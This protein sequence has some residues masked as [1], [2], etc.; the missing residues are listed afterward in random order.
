M[1]AAPKIAP[2]G[3]WSSPITAEQIASGSIGL[4]Q[5]ALDARDIYW[6]EMRPAES[7]RYVIVRLRDG[8]TTDVL[9]APFSARTR[10][11]EYGGGAFTV[12]DG[13]IYFSNDGDQCLYRL[14]PEGTPQ[15][16]TPQDNR[17]YADAAIDSRRQ[18]IVCVCEDHRAGGEPVNTI[19]AVNLD[20]H[21]E[22][23]SLVSGHD[24]YASPRLSPDGAQL[25]WLTWN[26]PDM[27]WDGT[28]L[29]LADI[30][31]NGSLG[32]QRRVAGSRNESVFQPA[33]APDGTLYF[34][35]DRS[36]WWN[37]YRFRSGQIEALAPTEAEFGLP[38]W[39][40]GMSTYAFASERRI[41]CAFNRE[42]T[43]RLALLD[44]ETRRMDFIE[45][46][47]TDIG[48]VVAGHGMA[49]FVAASP[50]MLS[51]V[52]CLDLNTRR[53][54]IL[55]SSS[56]VAPDASYLAAP[57]TLTYPVSG[58][59]AAHAF[60]YPPT[61]RD[62][63]APA[64]AKPPLLVLSHGGPT[65]AT[66]SALNLK[67]QYW[68][69]RGF[70]VLD[71]NYRGS[72]GYGRDYRMKLEGQW[73]VADVEDCLAGARYLV[74]RGL[75]D[76]ARLAIRGGSAGGYTTLCALTFHDLFRAGASYY[77]VS[78]LESLDRD[79]H[80][81]EARYLDRL[82]GPYPRR[83]DLYRNRSPI[84]H[85]DRLSCPV[86]FFQGLDDKVVPPDQTETMVNALRTKD[87]PVA[88]VPLAGESHGFRRA[89]NIRRALEAELYFYSRIFGFTPAD[90]IAPVTIEN[91]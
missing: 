19:V 84:H 54:E 36:H 9:P 75:A 57:Q 5:I 81:F 74:E 32:N 43:W 17:R 42:A 46:P 80:K 26:H 52:V 62:F 77:G 39:V 70:A 65:S 16:I 56:T 90:A 21:G 72:T 78:D 22:P 49:V 86:I 64:G 61:N 45:T 83:Q 51:A 3:S 68:T 29:W 37:L 20:G 8:V 2:Y 82:I 7:G 10:V 59:E 11:H 69:S 24:F 67:L 89:E 66:S 30:A 44:T 15:P 76:A 41:V 12:A 58:G 60:Y 27:P 50:A 38:Q 25:A 47:F 13:V 14:P 34:V 33:F 79:T 6:S 91:L 35:S 88:Y 87:I 71:V 48:N 55:R 85:V 23:L 31:S 40:F 4:G 1:S 53:Y 28:E 18:R 73:G 63:R